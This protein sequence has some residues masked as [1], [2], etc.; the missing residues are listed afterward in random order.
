MRPANVARAQVVTDRLARAR[1]CGC[2]P[3]NGTVGG[4]PSTESAVEKLTSLMRLPSFRLPPQMALEGCW[5]G[6]DRLAVTLCRDAS[7]GQLD[8]GG[9]LDTLAVATPD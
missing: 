8:W 4:N 9:S 5:L 7:R 3:F 6:S 1:S 2:A